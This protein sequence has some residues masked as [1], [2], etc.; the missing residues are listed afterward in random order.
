MDDIIC[1]DD[2]TYIHQP[3]CTVLYGCHVSLTALLAS[4]HR[5]QICCLLSSVQCDLTV[6]VQATALQVGFHA[7]SRIYNIEMTGNDSGIKYLQP[8]SMDEKLT[9]SVRTNHTSNLLCCPPSTFVTHPRN[10]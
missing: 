2:N 8:F 5:G 6:V 3:L 10:S 4:L 7:S 9:P 1:M